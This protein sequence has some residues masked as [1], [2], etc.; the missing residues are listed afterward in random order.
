MNAARPLSHTAMEQEIWATPHAVHTTLRELQPLIAD[1]A[2]L[3]ADRRNVFFVGRGTSAN[4]ATYG[5]YLLQTHSDRLSADICPDDFHAWGRDLDLSDVVLVG[6]SQSGRTV[7]ITNV[8]EL[9]RTHGATTI[10]ITNDSCSPVARAADIALT[11]SAGVEMAVPATKTFT[12][13]LAA[14]AVL[15]QALGPRH[16]GLALSRIPDELERLRDEAHPRSTEFVDALA[17]KRGVMILGSGPNRCVANEFALKL[18]EACYLPAL[19]MS[20]ADAIHGPLALLDNN[21]PVIALGTD[22]HTCNETAEFALRM[23]KSPAVD[24]FGIATKTVML[25]RPG[26]LTIA[27]PRLPAWLSPLGVVII[28]Q[29][30]TEKLACRLSIDPDRPRRLTKVTVP[31]AG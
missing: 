7:E 9:G 4:A 10:A 30:I 11:T 21:F 5:S 26:A 31:Q 3:A 27:G 25:G 24:V 12:C 19:G 29:L 8:L 14:V 18:Q 13:Q 20:F 15:A 28:A 23:Q 2:S 16:C 6:L 22:F 17:E 1:I